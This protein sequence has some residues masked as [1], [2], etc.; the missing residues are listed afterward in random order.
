MRSIVEDDRKLGNFARSL[1]VSLSRRVKINMT[2]PRLL[3]LFTLA[4]VLAL[5]TTFSKAQTAPPPNAPPQGTQQND[6]ERQHALELY[7]TG[8]FVAPMPVLEQLSA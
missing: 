2:V 7:R 5:S 8:K 1:R 4:I 6:A 3:F